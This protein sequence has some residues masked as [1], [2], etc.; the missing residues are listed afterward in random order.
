[1][2]IALVLYFI[3]ALALMGRLLLYGIR[4]TKTL[5]WLLAIFTIPVGGMLLYFILG[6]NR[7]KNKFYTLK[8]T[9]SIS[10]YLNKVHEYYK[11]IDSDSDIPASIKKHIKLVKLI[12]KGANFVP[13]V[14]NEIIPLKNGAATFEAIFKA[15]ETAKKFV[16]IQYYIFEEGDL[17][18][19]FKTILIKK[20]KEGVEVRLLYDA[21]GS[22]TLSHTYIN[23]LKAEGIEVFGFLPMKLG[24]FLSSINYRN[25]RKIVV[26]DSVYGFTGGI[27]VADKYISG[28]P[29]LGNWY[30]MHLQLKGT[31]VN[32]L[33]SV[34]AMD[35]SFASNSDNLLNTQYFLKHSTSGKTVAQVV[36]G[37]PDSEF[38]AI[39]QLYFSIINSAKKYVYI[40]NPYI[41]P[42]EALKEAM[43]VAALSGID[44]RLLLSTKSDSFLVKWTVRSIFEDLLE[45]GVKIF[46]F[47]DGFLHSKVIISDDE[48]TTIGTAN[49]DI[50][51]F[52]QNYEVNVL[53][54]D[55]EIT[56]KLK[57]DF[58]ID[59][60]K[61][62]QLNYNQFLKR[63]K[64]ERLKEG[65]AKVFSP[66]L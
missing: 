30:D 14:G 17:A 63:P 65:L 48:L 33:Q 54:Y 4:P 34:F 52:E 60:K 47:P 5:A 35:W 59:C 25:H 29:D 23:S 26:V 22:R 43:Q 39:Q 24:R 55:K 13:T 53:M 19:K 18:E 3:L 27:N 37:G 21:L 12:I 16:H 42:G 44:I 9:K 64:I 40:T 8:K 6:R 7:R 46:L 57:L 62:N 51:S 11:T 32:S 49:L 36:A 2:T 20:A 58:I 61:S 56:T 66:V 31:I 15:L 38:S 50:R 45:S 10:K 1:M 28:D 41:I